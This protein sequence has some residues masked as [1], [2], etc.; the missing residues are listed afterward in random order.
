MK[1]VIGGLVLMMAIA[2]TGMILAAPHPKAAPLPECRAV[3][4]GMTVE[5][6][7]VLCLYVFLNTGHIDVF[8]KRS[9]NA[10]F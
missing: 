7:G 10:G 5:S 1:A 3:D 4:L 8:C 9:A 2:A 6:G